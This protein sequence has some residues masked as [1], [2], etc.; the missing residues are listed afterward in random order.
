MAEENEISYMA[1]EPGTPMLTS[2]GN[3]F[4]VV[5]HVLQL[6]EEDLFDGIVVKAHHGLRFVDRNQV[7]KITTSA[8][9][10]TIS[11]A[12]AAQLPAPSGTADYH[13]D[14][15]EDA[16]QSLTAHFGRLFGREHWL[17]DQ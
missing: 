17:K 7:A 5:E 2:S 3:E 9:H 14:P 13:A 4:G 12:D 16:G 15:L 6:P 10:C 11:D 8:V 1:L